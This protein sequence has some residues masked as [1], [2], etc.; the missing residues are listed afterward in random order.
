MRQKKLNRLVKRSFLALFFFILSSASVFLLESTH[1]PTLPSEGSPTYFYS[2][3]NQDDLHEVYLSGIKEAKKSIVLIIFSL[4]DKRIIRALKDKSEEGVF[5]TVIC[6]VKSCPDVSNQLGQKVLLHRRICPG[7]MHQKLLVID[8]QKVWIGSAN[9]TTESLK[10]HGNLVNAI[11]S[12]EFSSTILEKANAMI[13]NEK[14]S[15]EAKIFYVDGQKIEFWLLPDHRKGIERLIEVI[16]SAKKSIR[17]A[18]FT[19]TRF[20]L[21]KEIIEAKK[22]GIHVE[23]ALDGTSSKGASKKVANLFKRNVV[24][25]RC[26]KGNALLHYKFLYVDE[27]ILV[28][29]S[30]NWTVGAFTKNED[31]FMILHHLNENQKAFMEKLW[32]AILAE[33]K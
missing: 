16:R 15:K 25:I 2:N 4:T 3:Q 18:M 8:E 17:V 29:G 11:Y 31:C 10:I 5:V 32:Q 1:S 30:A 13:K 19:W 21:A 22:K 33:T 12:P 27:D 14:I 9:L 28:N 7:I 24:P 26:S 23:I 20:D 6:D